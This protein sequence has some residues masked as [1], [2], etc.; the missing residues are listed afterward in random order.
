MRF[1]L[2]IFFEMMRL[3]IS[4][5]RAQHIIE[6]FYCKLTPLARAL[7]TWIYGGILACVSLSLPCLERS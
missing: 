2:F 3:M 5:V 6:P 7:P 4:I 1:F